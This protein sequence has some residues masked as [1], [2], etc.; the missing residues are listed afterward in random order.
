MGCGHLAS[1][2]HILDGPNVAHGTTN[3]RV[4]SQATVER[5][6]VKNTVTSRSIEKKRP[7]L[8]RQCLRQH[9]RAA[10]RDAILAAAEETVLRQGYHAVK[11]ADI[12]EVT[13]VAVGTLY[14]YFENKE[15][16]V[17]AITERNYVRF[18]ADL[19]RPFDS[20]EPMMQLQQ[21]VG[22]AAEFVERNGALFN[23]Y[24]RWK[25]SD[26]SSSDVHSHFIRD[27]AHQRFATLITD[28]L[29]RAAQTGRIRRDIPVAQ[30][31]WMLLAMLEVALLDWWRR[32]TRFSCKLRGEQIVAVFLEGVVVGQGRT[33]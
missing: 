23:L 11:M 13:G 31:V 26:S 14:K 27:A 28:L 19:E 4:M 25:V 30:L 9:A 17:I 3:W 1:L 29:N 22:R 24:R 15:A 33:R 6:P 16:V 10:Y 2:P 7:H 8:L 20:D 5:H 18:Q 32:P 21:L 12:A